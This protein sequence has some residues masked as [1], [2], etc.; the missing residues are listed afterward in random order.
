[1][2]D[3]LRFVNI[4]W[5]N[6]HI[7]ISVLKWNSNDNSDIITI[8]FILSSCIFQ[9]FF[10]FCFSDGDV[11]IILIEKLVNMLNIAFHSD[12]PD[13]KRELLSDSQETQALSFSTKIIK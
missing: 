12:K 3:D 7:L 2:L 9:Q 5:P 4:L 6:Y 11:F 13:Y 8:I 1:M 10:N